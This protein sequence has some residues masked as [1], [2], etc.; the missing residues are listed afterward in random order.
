MAT[1]SNANGIVELSDVNPSITDDMMVSG[2]L[3][4]SSNTS[5]VAKVTNTEG[6][7]VFHATHSGTNK[8]PFSHPLPKSLCIRGLNMVTSSYI[9]S[10]L[11]YEE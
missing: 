2:F 7:I 11:V 4:N 5:W 8:L 9:Q 10:I 6:N 3:V 1:P